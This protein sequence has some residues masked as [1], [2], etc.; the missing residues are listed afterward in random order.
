MPK[1]GGTPDN[2]KTNS[3]ASG[4][5]ITVAICTRNRAAL[6]GKAVRSVLPQMT[7]QTELLIV[8]NASTDNTPTMA[9]QLAAADPRVAV[10]REAEQG[11]S[12][13]RNAALKNARGEF[14]LFLDDDE[15]AEPDWLVRYQHFL[16]SPPSEKI[17]AV[18]GAVLVEFETPPARRGDAS[19]SFNCGDTP[20]RLPY[21]ASIYG[22]NAAYHRETALAVGMF[23]TQLKRREDS[24]LILRLQNA[25][26]EIWW[27]PGAAIWHLAPAEGM[28]FRVIFRERFNDGRYIAIQRLKS[29]RRGLDRGFYRI[30]RIIG[31]P[32]HVLA[33][34]LAALITLPGN[35]PEATEHLLQASRNCGIG[36]GMLVNWKAPTSHENN[37]IIIAK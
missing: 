16:S 10:V 20:K 15:T 35:R 12:A 33:R 6:L 14:V 32:F 2:L 24:D 25:G 29:R 8:D 13:A 5:L 17:G 36:W 1:T 21:P 22:G 28:K 37:G 9:A 26:Y 11:I 3:P 23:D 19:V 30:A 7:E 31:A 4:P 18:G 34:L 27:L